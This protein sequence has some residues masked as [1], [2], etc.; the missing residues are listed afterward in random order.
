[1]S[2]E[3]S[4]PTAK[5]LGFPQNPRVYDDFPTGQPQVHV[6]KRRQAEGLGSTP[7]ILVVARARKHQGEK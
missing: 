7:M 4:L 5:F 2:V 6:S 3:I 1:M